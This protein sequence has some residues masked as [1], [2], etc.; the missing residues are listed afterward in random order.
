[1]MC[2]NKIVPFWQSFPNAK[3]G[4]LTH[5]DRVLKGHVFKVDQIFFDMPG[6]ASIQ[7]DTTL[8]IHRYD[9][10]DHTLTFALIAGWDW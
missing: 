3:I 4:F 9:T 7:T 8:F 6:Q 5:Q 1:M 2:H 10:G